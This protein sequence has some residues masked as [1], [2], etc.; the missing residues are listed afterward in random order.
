M[1][2]ISFAQICRELEEAGWT[3]ERRAGDYRVFVKAGH[4]PLVV[5]VHYSLVHTAYVKK[6]KR[7]VDA[8]LEG[9]CPDCKEQEAG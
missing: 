4:L 8:C 3:L 7:I 1:P 5:P 9:A 6:I 2:G